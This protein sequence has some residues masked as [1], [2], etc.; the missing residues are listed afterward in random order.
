MGGSF[1]AFDLMAVCVCVCVC[2]HSLA[3]EIEEL[4][5]LQAHTD[6][7]GWSGIQIQAQLAQGT[8]SVVF[9]QIKKKYW[10]IVY[11]Q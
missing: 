7:R 9:L 4:S 3:K 6:S 11:L 8:D 1:G 5:N 10:N 2:I